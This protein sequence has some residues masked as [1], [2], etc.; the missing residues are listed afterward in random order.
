MK[1]LEKG[2]PVCKHSNKLQTHQTTYLRLG[3][4]TADII[5]GECDSL[6]NQGNY[7]V[8]KWVP[9]SALNLAY[10]TQYSITCSST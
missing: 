2:S 5:H 8:G 1:L 10:F 7:I 6:W 3:E 4:N 9:T